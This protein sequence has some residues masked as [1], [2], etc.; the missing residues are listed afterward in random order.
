MPITVGSQTDVPATGDPIVSPWYQDTATKVVH[1]FATVAA[2]DAWTTRPEG[3]AAY[4]QDTNTLSIWTGAAWAAVVDADGA[5][6]TGDLVIGG[7]PYDAVSG[8][9]LDAV[10]A[11]IGRVEGP[12]LATLASLTLDRGGAPASDVGAYFVAFKRAANTT[13]V[14]ALIG[15]ITMPSTTSVAYNTTSDP[16]TKTGTESRGITDAAQRAHD[17]GAAAWRGQWIDPETGQGSGETWDFLSSHDIEDAAGYAVTGERDATDDDGNPVYQQVNY[18]AL[19]PLL[20]AA[21]AD[22]LD[23]ITA[24]ETAAP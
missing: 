15:S 24:L 6:M 10:G 1:R 13:T 7:S 17:I 22:A 23:R 3:A 11:A 20:F 12:S 4:T 16:R 2:R 8:W 9:K 5:I 19:V 18:P 14:G 21:L